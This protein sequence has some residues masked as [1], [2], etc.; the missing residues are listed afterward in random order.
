MYNTTWNRQWTDTSKPLDY[1]RPFHRIHSPSYNEH[2]QRPS[3]RG[4]DCGCRSPFHDYNPHTLEIISI[5]VLNILGAIPT[6]AFQKLLRTMPAWVPVAREG[7]PAA[8]WDSLPEEEKEVE[9]VLFRSFQTW[10]DVPVKQ[11]HL[12]YDWNFHL[13]PAKGYKYL[14]GL[15]NIAHSNASGSSIAVIQHPEVM[16]CEWDCG[17]IGAYDFDTFPHATLADPGPMFGHDWAWPMAG[18]YIWIAGRWIYDCGH[19]SSETKTGPNAGLMRTEL[20]PCK[21]IASA[22]WEAVKFDDNER[23][24][25]AI[26][27]MFFACRHGGYKTFP[28]LAAADYEFIV[29]LPTY[30]AEPVEYPLGHTP[31]FPLN[32][33]VIRPRLLMKLDYTSFRNS[34]GTKA[35]PGMA[36]PQVEILPPEQPG[37]LPRQARVRIPLTQ[38]AGRSVDSYGVVLS[39]GWHDPRRQLAAKVKKVDISFTHLEV[40]EDLH[41]SDKA[42]WQIKVGV[43]GRWFCTHYSAL[44]VET[45]SFRLGHHATLYL[46]EDDFISINAH[47]ME[48]NEVGEVMRESGDNRTLKDPDGQPYTWEGDIDQRDHEHASGIARVITG[49][50]AK[51][52]NRQNHPLGLIDPGQPMAR[53]DTPNPL[54][55]KELMRLTRGPGREL[56]GQLTAL[57]TEEDDAE[58]S[59][60]PRKRDYTLHYIIHYEDLLS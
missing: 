16:E 36:D 40:G 54:Q 53:T 1:E 10:T 57:I 37:S 52:L 60:D 44:L 51:T 14:R 33:L 9:G 15:G 29:D 3:G 39:L 13:V 55:V 46:A 58:L 47:G 24:V 42:T 50:M 43:N 41:E 49:K 20:H 17:A 4:Y 27:F 48:E 22:R 6:L 38:L 12:W 28:S 8:S 56:R 25:P 34:Y 45:V 18:Q 5:F 35:S 32:T 23:H 26:Q 11:W 30:Q 2:G 7:K 21:A 59:F 19:A 31:D